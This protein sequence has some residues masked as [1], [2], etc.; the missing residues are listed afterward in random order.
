MLEETDDTQPL[1]DE[2]EA[3]YRRLVSLLP[4]LAE[5]RDRFG[6]REGFYQ[7]I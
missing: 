6:L 7:E 2:L 5:Y 4:Q 1:C 3:I